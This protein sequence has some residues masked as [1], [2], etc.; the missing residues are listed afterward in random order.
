MLE[1]VVIEVVEVVEVVIVLVLVVADVV[2]MVEVEIIVV[3][4]ILA[5]GGTVPSDGEASQVS[6]CRP[7]RNDA[8]PSGRRGSLNPAG[9]VPTIG[10]L[11]R[12][13]LD[14]VE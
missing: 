8:R 3:E 1:E 12:E 13:V 11:V 2:D 5:V 14:A 7:W 6:T 9:K 10:E 4:V